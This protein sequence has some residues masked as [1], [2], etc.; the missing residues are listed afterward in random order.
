M[1]ER[2]EKRKKGEGEGGKKGGKLPDYQLLKC[3]ENESP[4]SGG[5]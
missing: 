1:K 5:E 4:S 3:R 2:K